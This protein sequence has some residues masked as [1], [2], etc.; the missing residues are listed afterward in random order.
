M[1]RRVLEGNH[2]TLSVEEAENAWN[3]TS[4]PPMS[5]IR[6]LSGETM[7]TVLVIKNRI[8]RGSFR[9]RCRCKP[10]RQVSS[11][12]EQWQRRRAA[13]GSRA[14]VW[15][16]MKMALALYETHAVCYLALKCSAQLYR[17]VVHNLEAPACDSNPGDGKIS[18]AAV[19]GGK[20]D[21]FF[22]MSEKEVRYEVEAYLLGCNAAYF[23]ENQPIFRRNVLSPPSGSNSKRREKLALS[24]IALLD[25]C[26]S[27]TSDYF[28]WTARCCAPEHIGTLHNDRS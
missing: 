28:Q 6:L 20:G 23:V 25:T 13:C 12:S 18:L 10:S 27:K 11:S 9:S 14:I 7:M 1:R 16:H 4:N 8:W 24:R 26:S 15:H 17:L 5:F 19:L 2:T 3:Y 21:H 22:Q